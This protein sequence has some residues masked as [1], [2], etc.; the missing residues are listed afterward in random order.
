M[1]FTVRNNFQK[2]FD[3]TL[4]AEENAKTI[5]T[6]F[7]SQP[8]SILLISKVEGNESVSN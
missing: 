3:L 8:D 2:S 1:A 5:S 6:L 7:H 4:L